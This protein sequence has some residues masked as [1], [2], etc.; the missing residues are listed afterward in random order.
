MIDKAVVRD[1]VV[2]ALIV[3]PILIGINYGD[4]ILSGGAVPMAKVALTMLVPFMVAFV[5]GTRA[6]LRRGR[7]EPIGAPDESNS[8]S[9]SQTP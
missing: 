8:A 1:A 5:S 9:G 4:A 3:G 2:T 7:N 6:A